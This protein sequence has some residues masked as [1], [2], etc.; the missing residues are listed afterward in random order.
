LVEGSL[1]Y[2]GGGDPLLQVSSDGGVIWHDLP[3][4]PVL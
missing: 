4:T 1:V 3:V 2:S